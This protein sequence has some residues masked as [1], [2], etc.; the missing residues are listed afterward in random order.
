V[1]RG[2][3]P[4]SPGWGGPKNWNN[5]DSDPRGTALTRPSSNSKLK[6]VLS[7]ERAPQKT[8]PQLSKENFKEKELVTGPDGSLTHGQ[9]GRLTVGR[10]ITST[11][12]YVEPNAR[13]Y[14]WASLLLGEINTG[15]WP[16]RLGKSQ[17]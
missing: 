9:F 1:P 8:N 11:F 16:S 3:K 6:H 2:Y 15:T 5:W 12:A 14:N 7:S 10:N 13:G 4:S 17:K